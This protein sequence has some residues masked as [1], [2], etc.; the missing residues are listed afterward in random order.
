MSNTDGVA[1]NELRQFIERIERLTEE[2]ASIN[3]DK[4]DVYAE[5]KGRGYDTKAIKHIVRLRAQDASERSEFDAIV[6]LY[7]N[8]LG[9]ASRA[10]AREEA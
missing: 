3:A 2:V 9:M 7:L 4:R 1:A 6:D 5:A 10:P 8:A